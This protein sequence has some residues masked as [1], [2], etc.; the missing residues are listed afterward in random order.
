MWTWGILIIFIFC[1][2]I[3][4]WF[5]FNP[6]K[7]LPTPDWLESVIK[8]KDE[9]LGETS[10]T[11]YPNNLVEE[12]RETLR[13]GIKDKTGS[14]VE[15]INQKTTEVLGEKVEVEVIVDN[16]STN[17]S[18][19]EEEVI[20]ITPGKKL[21]LKKGVL[22]SLKFP[23]IPEGQCLFIN[24]QKYQLEGSVIKM[25]FNNSG[26][27]PLKLDYC[28]PTEKSLGEVVVD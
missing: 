5:F 12:S 21:S 18:G 13:E 3:G 10:V 7:S 24:G 14:V 22:Y 8:L 25:R 20:S 9:V 16:Q 17:P 27:F 4:G 19:T 26:S 1:L 2:G 28:T 15:V 11:E 23:D 6:Q